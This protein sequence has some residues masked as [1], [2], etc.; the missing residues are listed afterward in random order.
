MSGRWEFWID[1]GGTFTDVV[2]R[3]PDGL[4]SVS[5]LLSEDPGR[6]ADAAAEAV[7]RTLAAAGTPD[8][9]VLVKMGTTVATNALLERKGEPVLL[10]TTE[11]LGD[12]LR[13]GWQSRPDIFARHIVLPDALYVEVLEVAERVGT[14]GTVI[15][16]L[17]EVATRKSLQSAYSRGLRSVAI[18]LAHGWKHTDHEV[19][20]ARLARDIGFD[21]VSVSH[22]ISPL[23]RMV[24]RGDTTT[25]DAYLSPVLRRYVDQA[26]REMG[27]AARL[28]FMQSNGGLIDTSLFRGKDAV[29]SGPA[30][31]VIGMAATAREAGFD[32]VIGFDMGGTSTDVCHYAG[33]FERST[34]RTVAGVRLTAPMLDIHTVAAGGGSICRFDGERLRVGPASAGA[35]PGPACY[36]RGG[37]L[38]V[39]DCNLVLGRIRS[40]AFPHVFGPD[41]DQPLDAEAAHTGFDALSRETGQSVEALAEGF[42][43]IAVEHMSRAIRQISIQRGH[44]LKGYALACFGG[45]GGQHAC[46]VADALGLDTVLIHPMAGVLSAYGMG[47]A[48]L[49]SLRR[50]SVERPLVEAFDDL[51]RL[52]GDLEAQGRAE[53]LSQDMELASLNVERL[54]HVKYIGSDS[55]LAVALGGLSDMTKAFHQAHLKRFGFDARSSPLVL[56][57][58]S[59]EVVGQMT[60]QAPRVLIGAPAY[61]PEPVQ[62]VRAIF[63]EATRTPLFD[64]ADLSP[65]AVIDGP[66]II[67]EATATTVVEPGWRARMDGLD[68]LVLERVAPRIKRQ[69]DGTAIDPIRLELFNS[70]FMAVAERMGLALQATARSVNIKERLDFSCALFDAEGGL[71]ANAPHIPVHLGSMGESIR[72]VIRQRGDARDGRGMQRGDAYVLNAPYNGGTHLPDITV[73]QPVFLEGASEPGFY[74]AARGH[75]AD[76]GGITP[77]SMPPTS[78]S[79]EEEGVLI[80]D[81]LLVDAG[82]FLEAETRALLAS[83]R[84]PARNPDQNIADLKA[85]VAA[86]VQGADELRG[87]VDTFGRDV[88]DAYMGHVQDNAEAAVR[89]AIEVLNDGAYAL[90]MDEGAVIRVKVTVNRAERSAVIDF[91]GTSAQLGTNFN[92]PSSIARAACLYVFRTLVDDAIPLN[93]GCLKPL[94][95]ILPEGSMLSPH[96]PAAVVAGNVETSQAVVDALYGALGVLAASQGTMNNFTF[97][98]DHRQ[99]YETIAGGSGAGPGFDGASA[100]QTHMTN[101]R[102]TD[103]EVLEERFPVRIEQFSIRHGSGGEGRYR[104]GDGVLRKVR[105]LEPMTAA[106]LSNRRRTQPFGAGGG[107]PGASGQNQIIRAT[108]DTQTLG[109]TD[110]AEMMAGDLFVI[111][112]PGGGGFGSGG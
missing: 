85:Q 105:F 57:S 22:E 110:Q 50:L 98:D 84:W 54:A 61:V 8:A 27:T 75:H 106:I 74:V 4:L 29:L 28:L 109:S 89:R 59:V 21:Q 96:Y 107:Q 91:T 99:Y 83:N 112:T 24:G 36:G 64:R 108:G 1:R 62:R 6:Y 13:I 9:P 101:S 102:L 16:P 65:G 14:D 38:T 11:G 104:G 76:V 41:G 78:R 5:K 39:T 56:D 82:H 20:V 34:E 17:D 47:L 103:V 67:G 100:V 72:T 49:R 93:E 63:D 86:C 45:A 48:A 46:R 111:A 7:R 44:D 30:G 70:R 71:I 42:L 37:P 88:V 23:I 80:D 3:A 35:M 55:S 77:G 95:L 81:A 43:D 33:V 15:R 26:A 79:V 31:G 12:V 53:I 60:A 25:M 66:A 97:G 10:V 94:T 90:E 51:A 87:L 68:N 69:A 52:A 32:R 73:I 58:I 92:A 18:V 40:E 2:A 19:R